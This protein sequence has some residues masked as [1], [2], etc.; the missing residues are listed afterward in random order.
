MNTAEIVEW[1]EYNFQSIKSTFENN[2]SL[3]KNDSIR[4]SI[5]YTAIQNASYEQGIHITNCQINKL[6][7]LF[8]EKYHTAKNN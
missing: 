6:T 4:F 5:A 1:L 7:Y 3:T 2:N 8:M